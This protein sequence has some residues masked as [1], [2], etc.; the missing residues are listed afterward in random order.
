MILSPLFAAVISPNILLMHT[1]L[2]DD[3]IFMLS[4]NT[5]PCDPFIKLMLIMTWNPDVYLM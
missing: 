2:D 4:T 5:R 1:I 3:F